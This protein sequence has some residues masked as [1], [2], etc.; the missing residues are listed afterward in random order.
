MAS[1]WFSLYSTIKMM[2]G[3]IN[4]RFT[5]YVSYVNLGS[6]RYPEHKTVFLS[7]SS[8]I[9]PPPLWGG[10]LCN[11][12]VTVLIQL[13]VEC[14]Q[15]SFWAVSILRRRSKICLNFS[16]EVPAERGREF[17]QW[18]QPSRHGKELVIVKIDGR[19]VWGYI[20]VKN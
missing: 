14:T 2:H 15:T 6:S 17:F 5:V 7:R 1:S 19:Q 20:W 3:P 4:I 13:G 9:L 11:L 12:I 16:I 18:S 10:A 8:Q